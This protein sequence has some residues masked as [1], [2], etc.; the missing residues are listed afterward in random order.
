MIC[1]VFFKF[2]LAQISNKGVVSQSNITSSINQWFLI[3]EYQ[4]SLVAP[5]KTLEAPVATLEALY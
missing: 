3:L 2:P 4:K 1:F 5:N